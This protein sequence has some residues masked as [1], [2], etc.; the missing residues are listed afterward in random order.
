MFARLV[1]VVLCGA[2]LWA[3]FARDTGAGGAPER[4]H[5][6]PG[7]SLWSIASAR[8]GGDPR[9]AVWRLERAN[10][11]NGPTI[12]PGQILLLP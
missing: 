8:Y 12:V 11:L 2:L 10:G 9:E 3:I 4:Y 1:I 5:V 6:R 7:D